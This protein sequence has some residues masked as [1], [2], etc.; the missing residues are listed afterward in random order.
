[1]SR[2]TMHTKSMY[3]GGAI[4]KPPLARDCPIATRDAALIDRA[5]IRAAYKRR[6]GIN[7]APLPRRSIIDASR[8]MKGKPMETPEQRAAQEALEKACVEYLMAYAPE[9]GP[10]ILTGFVAYFTGKSAEDMTDNKTSFNWT[11]LDDQ[12]IWLTMG[13]VNALSLEVDERYHSSGQQDEED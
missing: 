3:T 6:L 4:Q 8:M 1:M 9:R 12:P 11:C 10:A 5:I 7:S 2:L 13:L